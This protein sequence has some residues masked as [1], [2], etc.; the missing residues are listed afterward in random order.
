[1]N[2]DAPDKK[3]SSGSFVSSFQL[4]EFTHILRLDIC[5]QRAKLARGLVA[6]M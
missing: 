1:M 2:H 6:L 4:P 5:S 3:Y